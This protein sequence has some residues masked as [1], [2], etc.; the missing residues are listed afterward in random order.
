MS[1]R[2]SALHIAASAGNFKMTNLLLLQAPYLLMTKDTQDMT[3]LDVASNPK[4]IGLM[5]RYSESIKG[6]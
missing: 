2:G 1:R 6:D 5:N 4:V 3:P